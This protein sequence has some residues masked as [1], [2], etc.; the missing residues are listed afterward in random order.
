MKGPSH[1]LSKHLVKLLNKYITLNN[2]YN[3]TNSV[4]LPSD[5][6][7]LKING[8]HK[9]ITY[10]IKDPSVSITIEGTLTIIQSKLLE[11]NDLTQHNK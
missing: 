5:I 3:I 9:L 11:N 8:N 4:K 10:G 7:K 1:K 2:Y 6:T